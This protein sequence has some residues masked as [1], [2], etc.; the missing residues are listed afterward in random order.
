MPAQREGRRRGMAA[1]HRQLENLLR[2]AAEFLNS[3]RSR[4]RGKA[5]LRKRRAAV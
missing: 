2:R 4:S 5:Y 1:K 3:R